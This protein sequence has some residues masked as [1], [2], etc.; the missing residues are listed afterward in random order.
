MQR[1]MI[2]MAL[3][4][5]CLCFLRVSVAQQSPTIS[6][7]HLKAEVANR[8]AVAALNECS[9]RGYQ[10]SVAVV[11]RDGNLL[12]FLRSPL[13]APHTIET[14]QRKAFTA[15]SLQ[16]PTSR[17]QSRPDLSFA[18]GILLIVGGV[19]ICAAGSCYGGVAVAGADPAIDEK[20]AEAGIAS[21]LDDL[22]L[23]SMK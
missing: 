17:M 1:S 12:A 16:A 3:F 8:V 14:S 10:T 2:T 19:P 13:A 20:C 23:G 6:V 21:I 15:A 11:A 7:A 5:A 9:K 4:V 18:P 22:E